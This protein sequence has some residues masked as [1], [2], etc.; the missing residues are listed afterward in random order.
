MLTA[1]VRLQVVSVAQM[2]GHL[3]L[4]RA[5]PFAAVSSADFTAQAATAADPGQTDKAETVAELTSGAETRPG[6]ERTPSE[7]ERRRSRHRRPPDGGAA[8]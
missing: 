7:T 1:Y 4:H 3:M 6:Q 5:D 8:D 2:Q